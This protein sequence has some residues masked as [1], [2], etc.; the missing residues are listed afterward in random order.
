MHYTEL[1]E[2][3]ARTKLW[4]AEQ[5]DRE[6]LKKRRDRTQSMALLSLILERLPQYPLDP[7]A[8]K[9]LPKGVRQLADDWPDFL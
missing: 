8:L 3:Q 2:L 6:V 9:G 7:T 1:S 5:P 4:R